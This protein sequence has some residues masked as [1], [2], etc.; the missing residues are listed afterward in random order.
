VKGVIFNLVEEVVRAERGDDSWD[1]IVDDAGVS[2]AYTS[3]GSYPDDELVAL[4]DTVAAHVGTD[5][6]S[7][8]RHVGHHGLAILAT[9]YPEFFARH[10]DVRSFLL[11]L[12]EII[13]PEVRRLY[14]GAHVPEFVY[15]IE[16]D[17]VL[18]M[19]YTS[20]R[21]RCDLAEGLIIGAGQHYGQRVHVEQPQCRYRGDDV[22]V[23]RVTTR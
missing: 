16:S 22:C 2:G 23:L 6:G 3:L 9:R 15:R 4:A 8:I 1:G 10:D 17:D 5:T 11:T 14:P 21:G 20:E 12:N 13:H 7:V 19:I 18:E